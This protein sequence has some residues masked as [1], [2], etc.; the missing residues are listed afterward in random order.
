MSGSMLAWAGIIWPG[1]PCLKTFPKM[2][3]EFV[4][5]IVVQRTAQ[6]AVRWHCICRAP[7]VGRIRKHDNGS[8]ANDLFIINGKYWLEILV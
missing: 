3:E 8:K 7:F 1:Y 6:S 5:V 4:L 2:K